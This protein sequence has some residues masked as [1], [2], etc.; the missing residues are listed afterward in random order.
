MPL[1]KKR[2]KTFYGKPIE[3]IQFES[4]QE[5]GTRS[6]VDEGFW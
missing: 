5:I 3:K 1:F 4:I 2:L 6:P